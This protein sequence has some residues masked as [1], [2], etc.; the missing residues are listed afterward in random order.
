MNCKEGMQ[1]GKA[2][3]GFWNHESSGGHSIQ[4]GALLFD[5]FEVVFFLKINSE[6]SVPIADKMLQ[7]FILSVPT[8]A[9][10]KDFCNLALRGTCSIIP[11]PGVS[12]LVCFIYF[13][14]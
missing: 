8:E 2:F 7:G 4:A 5:P 13:F 9:I 3:G 6:F 1:S 10:C 12:C 11:D 14:S